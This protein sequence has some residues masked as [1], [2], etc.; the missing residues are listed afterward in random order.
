MA[1]TKVLSTDLTAVYTEARP[2]SRALFERA[3]GMLPG[4]ITHESRHFMPFLPY[5]VRAEGARKWDVDG[6]EYVDY[7]MGH[8]ALILGH[9]HPA[10]VEAVRKQVGLGTHYGANHEGELNWAER[11]T[12]LVPGAEMVRFTSSGTEA[13][14]LALRVARAASGKTRL[15]KFRG[16]FHGWHDAVAP[17][18]QPP[19]DE[20]PPG[21]T[22]AVAADTI[23]LPPDL[24]VVDE[25]LRHDR[26]VAAVIVEPSGASFGSVPLPLE[27][28]RGLDE[29]TA[30]HDVFLIVD[31]VITGFRWS[32]GGVQQAA[33]IS[34]DL[35]TLA[36]IVA[37]GLPGGA[38]A[39]RRDLLELIAPTGGSRRNLNHPG[40]FN[41]NPLSAAAGIACLDIVRDPSVQEGCS[42][43]G[44]ALRR[45][46]NAVFSKQGVRGIAY[47]DVSSFHLAFDGRLR[48][49]D[50]ASISLLSPEDLKGQRGTPAYRA[51]ALA[52]LIEG[53]QIFGSGGFLSIAHRDAEVGRTVDAMDRAIRRAGDV[54]PK[55]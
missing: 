15:V 12:R 53:V 26:D 20:I 25:T 44:A 31:E 27:F 51:I 3:G 11:I 7:A 32:P 8:G 1:E 22:P 36:K 29:V 24:A 55:A 2:K 50:P 34:G 43:M 39:G 6:H 42:R 14:L 41:A 17:G 4:G 18:L 52:M 45:E 16:H 19:Y 21:V 49:G 5:I 23:V 30:S 33:G 47:G 38:V 28:L 10:V 46:L 35:T 37:G 40:T 54:L 9:A 48:P 13:T